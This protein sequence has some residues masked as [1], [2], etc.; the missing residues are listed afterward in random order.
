MAQVAITK[1]ITGQDSYFLAEPLFAKGLEFQEL[2]RR[3]SVINTERLN[4]LYHDSRPDNRQLIFHR[5]NEVIFSRTNLD[6]QKHFKLYRRYEST[7]EEDYLVGDASKAEK[8]LGQKAKINCKFIVKTILNVNIKLLDKK[9]CC[10][11]IDD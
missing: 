2:T 5:K 4:K 11:K 9:L 3:T 10:K 1:R 7:L 6:W 8:I